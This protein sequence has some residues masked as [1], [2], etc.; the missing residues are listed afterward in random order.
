MA[1]T[2]NHHKVCIVGAGPCG[3]TAIKN[4]IDNGVTDVVCHEALDSIGGIWAYSEDSQRPSVYDSAHIISSRRMSAFRDFPMPESFP[5]F[6]SHRQILAYFHAYSERYN[7]LPHIRLNSRIDHAR[8]S[9]E[10]GWRL[11]VTDGDGTHEETAEFLI[12]AAGHHRIPFTPSISSDFKGEQLHSSE[13]RNSKGFDGKR[14]LVVGAGNSACDIAATLS[15]VSNHISLSIR[16][17]QYIIPKSLLG[18]PVDVQFNKLQ[19]LPRFAL[20]YILR[21]G[22]RLFVG[23]YE[24]YGLPKPQSNVLASHPTLNSDVLELLT[25]GKLA[26]HRG[27][28]TINNK[29]VEFSNGEGVEFDTIIWATGYKTHFPFLSDPRFDWSENIRLPLY[30]K[31]MPTDIDDIFFVGLIQPIGC[32]WALA[33]YQSGLVAQAITKK[34]QR[35]GNLGERLAKEHQRDAAQFRNTRRHA[36]EVEFHAYRNLLCSEMGL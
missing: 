23:D 4:S 3:L 16:T 28:K 14:V 7:L 13:Y 26:I 32:I 21:W 17:P 33:D 1:A 10:G 2:A 22:V 36:A 34:W 18:R 31:I 8:R 19:F 30:L 9:D 5:D 24:K 6:P 35:P 25:H 20:K 11:T 12:V 15:R 29:T 27:I